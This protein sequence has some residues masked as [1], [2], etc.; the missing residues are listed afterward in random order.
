M[1]WGPLPTTRSAPASITA[2][3]K[4]RRSPRFSPRKVSV[5]W[6]TRVLSLPSAPPWNVTITIGA[7]RAACCTRRFARAMS[8][9]ESDHVYDAKPRIATFWPPAV[10]VAWVPGRPVLRMPT[11]RRA[12]TVSLSPTGPKSLAWLFA[13]FITVN[14]ASFSH[15]A[16]DGGVRNA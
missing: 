6:G 12:A 5:P 16:Y 4:R 15:R 9:S 2:W 3:V 13:R 11:R 1:T 7:V 10:T 8:V 14:P